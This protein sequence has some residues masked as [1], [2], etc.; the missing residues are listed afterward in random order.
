MSQLLFV[1][2]LVTI[3]SREYITVKHS[4][5]TDFRTDSDLESYFFRSLESDEYNN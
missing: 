2:K 4:L 3:S 1:E 5:V